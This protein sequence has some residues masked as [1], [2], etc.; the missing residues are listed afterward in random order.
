VG[1][2][3]V[4]SSYLVECRMFE[5]RDRA[6]CDDYGQSNLPFFLACFD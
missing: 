4:A 1:V 3:L 6:A 5:F 2:T